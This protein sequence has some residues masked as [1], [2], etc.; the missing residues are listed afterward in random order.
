MRCSGLTTWT[1]L[2]AAPAVV[3]EVGSGNALRRC[4][5]SALRRAPTR[6][7]RR[8]RARRAPTGGRRRGR[9]RLRRGAGAAVGGQDGARLARVP[10]GRAPG[11]AAAAHLLLRA[12]RAL[13]QPQRFHVRAAHRRRVRPPR[14]RSRPPPTPAPPVAPLLAAARR[15]ARAAVG[16][17]LLPGDAGGST[18]AFREFERG[19]PDWLEVVGVR[20][21]QGRA[22]RLCA[23]DAARRRL[24]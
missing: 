17:R 20:A 22:G 9:A 18:A 7:S 14:Q 24:V 8:D 6:S 10:R 5:L 23:K 1:R 4:S 11:Q 12:R 16:E 21:G 13:G 15:G 3:L 2:P 19:A